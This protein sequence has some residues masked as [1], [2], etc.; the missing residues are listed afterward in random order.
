MILA[1][2][3][4]PLAFAAVAGFVMIGIYHNDSLN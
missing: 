4:V 1:V 2:K 3:F